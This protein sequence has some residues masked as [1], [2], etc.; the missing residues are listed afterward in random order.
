MTGKNNPLLDCLTK[1]SKDI[2]AMKDALK[3]ILMNTINR[4]FDGDI[5][6]KMGVLGNIRMAVGE[7]QYNEWEAL[8]G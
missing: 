4:D 2:E 1:Q 8:Y 6:Y 7:Q 5:V 3:A